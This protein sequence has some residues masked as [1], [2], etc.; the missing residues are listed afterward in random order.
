MFNKKKKNN[1]G[2]TLV[3]LLVVIA[4]IGI[5]AVVAVPSL[6][7][8]LDKAKA[9]QVVSNVKAIQTEILTEYANSQGY[10]SA[11]ATVKKNIAT[12]VPTD[13]RKFTG[14]DYDVYSVKV[15]GA[16][17]T[18]DATNTATSVAI[19]VK[20]IPTDILKNVND[21]LG[22]KALGDVKVVLVSK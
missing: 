10:A 2:F 6:F 22:A 21:Q 20:G 12:I 8:Q 1:K 13:N 19:E 9:A 11:A 18:Q 7:K 4:I 14:E 15:D 16:T 17:I 5:L 3:E